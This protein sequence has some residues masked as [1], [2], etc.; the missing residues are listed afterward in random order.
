MPRLLTGNTYILMNSAGVLNKEENL[1]TGDFR[2]KSILGAA[3]TL[4]ISAC[5][6]SAAN[7]PPTH[8]SAHGEYIEARTADVYTGPCFAKFRG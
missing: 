2:M 7:L 3:I 4:A 8:N 1:G 6:V 5:M